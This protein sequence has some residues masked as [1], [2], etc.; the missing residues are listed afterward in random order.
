MIHLKSESEIE[1]MKEGGIILK[2][3]VWDLLPKIKVGATTIEID[4][5]AEKLI[6]KYGGSPSFKEVKGY[7]W[8]TCQPINEQ[9]VHTPPSGRKLKL[10]D[11]YTLDIGIY[12]K[13]FHTDYADTFIIGKAKD[14]NAENFLIIGRKALT[15]AIAK[16][17]TGNHIGDV[18]KA[19]QDEIEGKGNFILRELTGHGIGKDLHEDPYVFGFLDRPVDKTPLIKSGLVI[20]V[21]VIYSTGTKEIAYEKSNDWSI[22]TADLSLSAC[23]EKTIAVWGRKSMILT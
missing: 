20:A 10:G 18:S 23:F 2:K 15:K 8:T 3:V 21:E 14:K 17:K 1:L 12:Y 22:V 5:T 16:V 13:G 9:V 7:L 19:I 6:Y 4:E 11:V